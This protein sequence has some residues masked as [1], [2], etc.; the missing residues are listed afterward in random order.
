[1]GLVL[2]DYTTCLGAYLPSFLPQIFM[3][4]LF[5][6]TSTALSKAKKLI[7]QFVRLPRFTNHLWSYWPTSNRG[8]Y[9][10]LCQNELNAVLVSFM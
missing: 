1:M 2:Y 4:C 10:I 7:L 6:L 3:G 5:S 8:V 9:S